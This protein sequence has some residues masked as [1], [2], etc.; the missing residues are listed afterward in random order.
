MA[1]QEYQDA[2]LPFITSKPTYAADE[3]TPLFRNANNEQTV[4]AKEPGSTKLVLVVGI[5]FIGVFLGA[6]D[7]TIIATLSAP[8]STSFNSLNLLAWV[9][10]AYIIATAACQPLSGKLTDIY[11]RCTGLVISNLLF[12]AGNLICGL[13]ATKGVMI[14]GRVI[15]GL[16]GGGLMAISNFVASDLVPLRR[17]GLIQ[18][19]SNTAFGI[20][21]GLG[22][23]FGG[24]TNDV[25]GWRVAFLA[26][27]PPALVSA[28]LVYVLVDIPPKPSGKSKLSRV[29]FLGAF[30]LTSTL[31]LLLVGLNLGGNVVP[32]SHPLIPSTLALS[33][34]G[35]CAFAWVE[36]RW[37]AEPVIPLELM[38]NRTV[39]AAC[40]NNWFTMMVVFAVL[41][42][43]PIWFQVRGLSTTAAGVR[44]IPHSIGVS[45]GS[46]LAGYIMK[47]T[48]EYVTLGLTIT[49]VFLLASGL[50]STLGLFTPEWPAMIFLFMIGFGYGGIVV[51]DLLADIAAVGHEHQAVITSANYAFRATGQTLGVCIASAIYQNVLKA[52]LW[53]RFGEQEGAARQIRKI[54]DDF[55]ELK[56]LPPLWRQGVLASY[57]EGLRAV[58]ITCLGLAALALVCQGFVR[59]H[60]LHSNLERK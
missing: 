34:A 46:L 43:S 10:S 21:S 37:A 54:L 35:L 27:V 16:G 60:V 56:R 45:I 44:L 42:Y 3:E 23:L 48:G 30:T 51:V 29:D 14:T 22:G 8:I 18:G 4:I 38:L 32:W 2:S 1:N 7:T 17:R 19:L 13:A 57:M 59:Q 6:L 49:T 15:S 39:A 26:Q 25:W 47:L 33:A 20:G 55:D 40:L 58:F 31:L 12:A 28:V 11:G 9:A 50:L 53:A 36:C 52:H 5:T 24:W 41:F